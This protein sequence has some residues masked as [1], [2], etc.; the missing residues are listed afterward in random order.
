MMYKGGSQ[1]FNE[2]TGQYEYPEVEPTPTLPESEPYSDKASTAVKAATPDIIIFDDAGIPVEA[3]SSLIFESLGGQEAINLVRSDTIDGANVD[4]S[5]ISNLKK[6]ASV[7]GP[8]NIMSVSGG[9]EQYFKNFAI[10]LD[11]HIPE[12]GTGPQ[13]TTVYIDRNNADPS[14]KNRLVV[15]VTNMKTNEQVDIQILNSG[16]YLDGIIDTTEES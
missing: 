11:I 15:D 14:Q 6:L 7:Y 3:L 4:Y 5:P 10:R 2:T 16:T 9:L 8:K 1:F 12:R 13:G